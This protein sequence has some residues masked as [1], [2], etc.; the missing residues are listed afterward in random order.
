MTSDVVRPGRAALDV[1]ASARVSESSPE[2]GLQR[3]STSHAA[4]AA[5]LLPRATHG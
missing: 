4:G 2:S 5:V 1:P 3:S